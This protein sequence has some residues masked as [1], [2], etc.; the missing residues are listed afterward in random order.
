MRHI[1]SNNY[2]KLE[3]YFVVVVVLPHLQHDP[4]GQESNPCLSS[5][6]SHCNDNAGSLTL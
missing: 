1:S 3:L 2:T 6:Q 5:D 4:L